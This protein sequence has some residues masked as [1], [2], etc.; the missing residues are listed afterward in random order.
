MSI[1]RQELTELTDARDKLCNFCENYDFCEH[2][3][4][5]L[6]INDAYNECDEL[7]D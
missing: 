3:Q 7:D 4:V 6:L 5:T 2:C 1:S